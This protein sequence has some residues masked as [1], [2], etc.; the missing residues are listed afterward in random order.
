[1]TY[2]QVAKKVGKRPLSAAAIAE[3]LG[4]STTGQ[5]VS[6]SLGL[7][8]KAGLVQRTEKGWVRL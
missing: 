4:Y 1:M 5:A 8:A 7:A 6:R 2:T 3:K